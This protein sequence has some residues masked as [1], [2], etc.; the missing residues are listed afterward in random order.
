MKNLKTFEKY[1]NVTDLY[2]SNIQGEVW[3]WLEL[4]NDQDSFTD[5]FGDENGNVRC[6]LEQGL[7]NLQNYGKWS[8]EEIKL[9]A[10]N[11]RENGI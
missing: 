2:N 11:V 8:R 9:F 4:N 3:E 5:L 10:K 1:S 6:S 7:D